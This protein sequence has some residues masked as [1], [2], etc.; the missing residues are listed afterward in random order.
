MA[1]ETGPFAIRLGTG[2][3]YVHMTPDGET[4]STTL[5]KDAH[6]FPTRWAA[7]MECN[8]GSMFAMSSI[9]PVPEEEK[10]EAV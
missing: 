4:V 1:V 2:G 8:K 10:H 7:L 3:F 6:H 9:W 5:I